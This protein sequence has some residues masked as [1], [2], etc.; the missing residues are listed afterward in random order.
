MTELNG[1]DPM[2]IKVTGP[3][4]FTIDDTT[5]MTAYKS[6]G[7]VKQVNSRRQPELRI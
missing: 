2:E 1:C 4:T 5:G 3:Y 6:G 7:Y